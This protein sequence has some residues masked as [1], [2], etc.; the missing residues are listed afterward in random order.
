MGINAI[1][2]NVDILDDSGNYEHGA[3]HKL[4][5]DQ[6][7]AELKEKIVSGTGFEHKR[8]WGCHQC[9]V[10]VYKLWLEPITKDKRTDIVIG[11]ST[12]GLV[13]VNDIVVECFRDISKEEF[14]YRMG[15]VF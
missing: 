9:L 2:Q 13:S 15:A 4:M 11:L 12:L 14:A 10:F 8:H 1:I 7:W 6:Q 3:W 5:I